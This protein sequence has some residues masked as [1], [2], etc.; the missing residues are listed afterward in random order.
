VIR[1]FVFQ[2][3]DLVAGLPIQTAQQQRQGRRRIVNERNIRGLAANELRDAR[4]N[5]IAIVEP[6]HE[7]GAGQ[8]VAP[9]EVPRHRLRSAP[10]HLP[11]RRCI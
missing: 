3:D 8:F 10:R 5:P 7:I 2:R 6:A 11:E 1:K 4:A 9:G